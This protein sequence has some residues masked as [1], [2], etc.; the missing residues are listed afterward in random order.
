M[1]MANVMDGGKLIALLRQRA[2]LTQT[3]LA[4]RAGISRSMVAQIE[5]GERRPSRKMLQAISG[6]VN[7]DA[8]DE[9]QLLAAYNFLPAGQTTEQIEA[10]LRSDKNLTP[11]Q[12]DRIAAF[13]REAYAR[14]IGE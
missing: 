14:A 9:R 7:A 5:T 10:L 2:T 13:V 6:A 11:E 1:S 4:Q 12:A 8:D 3:E